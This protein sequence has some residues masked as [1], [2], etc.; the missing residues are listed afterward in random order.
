MMKK[1]IK[2]MLILA[3]FF[4]SLGGGWLHFAYHPA[5]KTGF[6][7]VPLIAG[8]LSVLVITPLFAIKRTI[9]WA[10]LLNG[11]TVIAGTIT[12]AHFSLQVA[13]IWADILILWGK[14]AIGR[15]L[16]CLEIYPPDANPKV[17]G[18]GLIRFPNMGFWYVHLAL[19]GV[20]YLLG[21]LI[22]R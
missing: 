2:I 12:M 18:W 20:V 6:G 1:H 17:K 8:I 11:F 4:V 5:A 19:W 14:F 16:F 21:N 3:L 15:A 10:Y 22:W 9:R 7:W 13:P